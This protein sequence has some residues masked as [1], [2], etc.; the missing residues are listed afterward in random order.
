MARRE[1]RARD[2]HFAGLLLETADEIRLHQRQRRSE[3]EEHRREDG[4]A[5]RGRE[6]APVGYR[7]D[8]QLNGQPSRNRRID[9]PHRGPRNGQ[10]HQGARQRECQPL[11]QQLPCRT[12][13]AA[14]DRRADREL[15]PP[16]RAACQLHVRQIEARDEQHDAGH[17]HQHQRHHADL[18]VVVIGR[19]TD[20]EPRDRPDQQVLVLVLHRKRRFE[21]APGRSHCG[22]GGLPF[23][24]VAQTADHEE[25]VMGPVGERARPPLAA[26]VAAHGV[27]HAGRQPQFRGHERHR[28]AEPFRRDPDDGEIALVQPNR[29]AEDVRRRAQ[30][31]PRQVAEHRDRN[32]GPRPRFL[33]GEPAAER[34][35]HAERA[36]EVR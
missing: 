1:S 24:P 36:E 29:L 32:V 19:R 3:A 30:P 11:G 6:D 18:P 27:V 25:R 31:A 5:E 12:Q 10:R 13:P 14:A 34:R 4:K 7:I 15:L 33:V 20:R 26:E 8:R 17:R 21:P 16:R 2:R 28:P 35:R 23:Q 22:V 9:E